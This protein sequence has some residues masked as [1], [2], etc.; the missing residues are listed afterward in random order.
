MGK[1][2]FVTGEIPD[3]G[4]KLLRDKG[5]ELDM[6]Q[7]KGALPRAEFLRSLRAKAYD[8]VLSSL[9]DKIDDE[10]FMAAPSVKMFANYA[11]GFNNFD[12]PEAARHGVTLTNTPSDAVN[13]SVAEHTFAMM[14]AL[15]CRIV[16][17]DHFMR[18]GKYAGWD[19][20]LLIGKDLK[21]KVLGVL[22]AGRIGTYVVHKAVRGFGMRVVYYD[23]I[24]N[25][26]A[27]T[28]YGAEFIATPEEVLKVADA[29]TLHVPLIDSTRHLIN[30]ERLA[31]MKKTAYLVN[32][33]RGPVIDEAALVQAL[34]HGVIAGAALDVYENEPKLAAGLTKLPNVVLTP[35]IASATVA[36]RDDMAVIAATNI[37]DFLEGRTPK[38]IVK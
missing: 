18:D 9:T 4:L 34:K 19:A 12:V 13:E 16:E 20:T 3:A 6:Y 38:N 22:G 35:H 31:T 7:K 36:A 10:V 30:K 37:I 27:E 1:K 15:M 33:S 32:T 21:G 5:F 24:R 11:V 17:G 25:A 29:V 8:A 23:V 28:E 26:K 2:V 14:L